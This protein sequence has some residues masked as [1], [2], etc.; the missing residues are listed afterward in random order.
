MA[1]TKGM[2]P[3]KMRKVIVKPKVAARWTK[4]RRSSRRR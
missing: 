4:K 2:T 1:V 3:G